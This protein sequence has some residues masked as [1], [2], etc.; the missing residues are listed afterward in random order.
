MSSS[1]LRRILSWLARVGKDR[2]I[3]ALLGILALGAYLRLWNICHLFNVV[4]DYDEGA[5]SLAA[6]FISQGYIPYQDFILTHPPLYNLVLASVYKI[7]GYSFF[8]GRYFSI[9][10]SLVCMILIYF[11]AKKMYHP[12]AG[13]AAAAL[14]AVSPMMVYFGRR[15]VQETLGVSLLLVAI[16]FALDFINNRKQSS[17]LWCG[18]ALGLAA[19]TKY[20]F[21]PAAAGIILAVILL[22]TGEDFWKSIKKLGRWELW[23]MY[24]CFAA[25]FYALL[26]L[27]KWAV[28][29]DVAIPFLNPMYSTAGDIMVAVLVFVL[30]FFISVVLLEKN[31]PLKKWWLELWSLRCNKGLW[32]LIGGTVLGFICA[33]GFFWAKAP[34]EFASQ[35]VLIQLN[36]P[37]SEFPSLV[38]LVRVTLLNTTFLR[39]ACLP[40]LFT[41]PLILV[42]LNKRGFSKSDCFLAVALIVSLILS[43]G[44]YH[45]PRYYAS[46]FPFLFLGISRLVPP[47]NVELLT[48][49]LKAGLLVFLAILLFSL[50]LSLVLLRNYTGYDTLGPVFASNEEQV[51]EETIDFLEEAGAEKMYATSPSF[52]AMSTK[53]ESTL[54][55]DTFALLW[56]EKTP[57]QEI[58]TDL[59]DEGV[60]YVVL[61]GWTRYWGYPYEKAVAEL[62]KE[63]RRNSRLVKVIEPDSSCSAEIY[64]L[65]AEAQGIFNGDFDHWVTDKGITVPLG[66]NPVLIEGDGDLADISQAYKG[67]RNCV[68]LMVYEN[69]E[70]EGELETT[71]AGIAQTIRFPEDK[72]TVEVLAEVSTEAL[73]QAVLGP[74]INFVDYEGH[75]LAVGFSNEIDAES[76][77]Q[78]E[79]GDRVLVVKPAELGQWS[80]HSIDLPAYWSQAG[81]PQ[82]EEVTMLMVVSAHYQKPG[83]YAFCVAKAGI[84]HVQTETTE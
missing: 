42:L 39:M 82:C 10:L 44:F 81:W 58:V 60:D 51:Y 49:R 37:L 13:L 75:S 35:T 71:H 5:W 41:I 74:S 20:I 34:R 25:I 24:I 26:L 4:H 11:V 76:V 31:L 12:R 6:R 40:I 45:L 43:Q 36:R 46:V 29:L 78:S 19:A 15:S 7:F 79:N 16:Y 56:L 48:A 30:P 9:A 47:V 63:V 62:V 72:I 59:I 70:K 3:L 68:R 84:E 69:G 67:D 2:Q 38:A 22:A 53:L 64:L 50:S 23:V 1:P 17:L 14:F 21:I 18:L 32:M 55:F 66:W 65:D 52:Q 8:Y 54:A 57:P 28:R 73:G 77:F 27:L 83:A 33:T 80:E 61:D